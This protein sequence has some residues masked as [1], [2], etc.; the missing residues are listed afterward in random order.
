MTK[1][2][3]IG[4]M[5]PPV[6]GVAEHVRRL[7]QSL[8][9]AGFDFTFC[10][11]G[12]TPLFTMLAGI[13]THPVIHIHFSNPL[14]QVTFAIFCR[15]TG[16]KLLIT[17]HGCWG[18]YRALGN[19][20]V[21]LSARLAYIPIVQERASLLRALQCNPR[22]REIST[23]IPDPVLLPLPEALHS[24]LVARRP[25]YQA[26]FCTNA[27]NVTFDKHRKEVYGI[28]ELITRFGEYPEFQLLISD[29]SGNYRRYI[30]EYCPHIPANIFF[31][32]RLH[33]FK[34]VLR[35]SDAFI[36]NTTTDGVSLSVYESRE[37]GIPVLA[38]AAVERPA[39]C[40][41]FDNFL[42]T[43]L[44]EKL[45]EARQLITL[46][47]PAHDTADKLIELYRKIAPNQN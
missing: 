7:T 2:L 30:H 26:T 31:I 6:G 44:R 45:G 5:P 8:R 38:S 27:W 14:V 9:R 19:R 33:D 28:S 16:K 46:P 43:D 42:K 37:L 21:E 24:A 4:K 36:R 11:M 20:A 18:R 10:D 3:I 29:P 13:I 32:S 1:L 12:N 39:F 22:S 47:A 35:L 17:Y 25:Q 40:S 15:L 23:Y 41:V 34:S